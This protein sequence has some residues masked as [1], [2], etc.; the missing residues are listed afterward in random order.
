M[1]L[2]M[3]G[4]LHRVLHGCRRCI[5]YAECHHSSLTDWVLD[6]M[7][8]CFG[9]K[10]ILK[11]QV[12]HDSRSVNPRTHPTHT[13]ANRIPQQT[14]KQPQTP[15]FPYLHHNNATGPSPLLPTLASPSPPNN[16]P[17]SRQ[18]LTSPPRATSL[19]QQTTTAST[20]PVR[21][22]SIAPNTPHPIAPAIN[23]TTYAYRLPFTP[24]LLAGLSTT[25]M[26]AVLTQP[27]KPSAR[28][29]MKRVA[30]KR[31]LARL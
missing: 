8:K 25:S 26:R 31:S 23:P 18:Y 13:H 27:P 6:D 16:H 11:N 14:H 21:T 1:W 2:R 20:T 22:P 15:T 29:V 7:Q 28:D 5:W 4:C 19:P 24:A 12:V 9:S 30:C 10:C 3:N 17:A